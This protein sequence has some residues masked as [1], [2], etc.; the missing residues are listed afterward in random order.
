MNL[1]NTSKMGI[2]PYTYSVNVC[3]VQLDGE[4]L[5]RATVAELPDVATFEETYD[6]AY[7]LAI[8]AIASLYEAST[9]QGRK[10]PESR[11]NAESVGNSGRL[12]LRMPRWLH[13]QLCSQSEADGISLNQY[14][15]TLLSASSSINA[16]VHEASE[17]IVRTSHTLNTINK[18]IASGIGL[19]AM[20]PGFD[21]KVMLVPMG[22]SGAQIKEVESTSPS[23]L[24][25]TDFGSNYHIHGNA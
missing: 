25:I 1:G 14:L 2:D 18:E 4:W 23:S 8:E 10:F 6:A 17:K 22:A 16:L 11:S 24:T 13:A 3:K 5:F 19:A 9:E 21:H 7:S 12:T 15:I 20:T